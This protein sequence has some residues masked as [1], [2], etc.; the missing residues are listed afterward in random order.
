V[1]PYLYSTTCLNGFDKDK[2]IFTFTRHTRVGVGQPSSRDLTPGKDVR[3]CVCMSGF[4]NVCVCEGFV[5]C[6]CFW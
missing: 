4:C 2:F 6:G 1:E 3:V 5:M